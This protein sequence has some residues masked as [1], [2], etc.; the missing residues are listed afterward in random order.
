MKDENFLNIDFSVIQTVLKNLEKNNMFAQYVESKD[1]VVNSVSK[2]LNTGDVIS[3]G[4]SVTLEET[5]VLDLVRSQEYQFLDR[6]ADGLSDEEK[7]QRLLAAFTADAFLCSANA[8]TMD[9][10][11]YQVDGLSNRIAPLVF[12]P[13]NVIIVA[14]VNKIVQNIEAASDRVRSLTAPAIVA[15]RKLSAPCA[16]LGT[17]IAAGNQDI[18]AGCH[19]DDRRC[20][21]FLILGR[22]RIKNRIK[23]ILVGESLGF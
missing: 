12:G 1:D 18:A 14:G 17:C 4:G 20:C 2:L 22:Q 5:K 19:C 21:N 13:E 16:K 10:E 6:Y 7:K 3:V 23:V 8:I 15:R 11:L 9:G